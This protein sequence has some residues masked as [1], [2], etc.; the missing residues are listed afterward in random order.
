MPSTWRPSTWMPRPW[1]SRHCRAS[2]CLLSQCLFLQWWP[3]PMGQPVMT[4]QS[5]VTAVLATVDPF[6]AG[7][8]PASINVCATT[9][10]TAT[11]NP[12]SAGQATW[13][14]VNASPTIAGSV[15]AVS[16]KGDPVTVNPT[17]SWNFFKIRQN[18]WI[19]CHSYKN[20]CNGKYYN[21]YYNL[22]QFYINVNAIKILHCMLSMASPMMTRCHPETNAA[23]EISN[24][25]K[26]MPLW[27]SVRF[28]YLCLTVRTTWNVSVIFGP[29][30]AAYLS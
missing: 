24:K 20:S 22:I 17:N 18:R 28:I 15:A 4:L 19:N 16:A 12:A 30:I 14:Q 9:A 21:F 3:N 2:P 8:I 25:F 23:G 26:S 29:D 5:K 7:Q 10:V 6:T 13:Y 11:V 1:R 27:L